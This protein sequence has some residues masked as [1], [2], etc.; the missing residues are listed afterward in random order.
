MIRVG[1][2]VPTGRDVYTDGRILRACCGGDGDHDWLRGRQV[3]A[4]EVRS[5]LTDVD[6][7]RVEYGAQVREAHRRT[8]P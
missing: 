8:R 7:R 1:I 4:S 3:P 5:T 6:V 2:H